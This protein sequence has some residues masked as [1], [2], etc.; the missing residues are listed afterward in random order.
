MPKSRPLSQ[1][2]STDEGMLQRL[3]ARGQ[4]LKALEAH[5]GK[6]LADEFRGHWQ[7]VNLRGEELLLQCENTA[8]AT[9]LRFM[10]SELLRQLREDGMHK[11]QI[12]HV[13]VAPKP[14]PST[15]PAIRRELSEQAAADIKSAADGMAPELA[16]ALRRLAGRRGKP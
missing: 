7:L 8:W 13:R 15:P 11:L 6:L 1:L 3:A 2:F 12:I 4:R 5:I 14:A 16:A 10:Q 9:R